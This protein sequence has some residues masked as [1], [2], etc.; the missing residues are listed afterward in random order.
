MR[1][2]KNRDKIAVLVV[3]VKSEPRYYDERKHMKLGTYWAQRT[4]SIFFQFCAIYRTKQQKYKKIIYSISL[5]HKI[6]VLQY[7][8]LNKIYKTTKVSVSLG[9][10][11]P[12]SYFFS[13]MSFLPKI[14]RGETNTTWRLI[15]KDYSSAHGVPETAYIFS[16]KLPF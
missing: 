12:L 7:I 13:K 16:S 1:F 11:G 5:M 14:G 3:K 6:Y 15:S 10:G 4:K 8:D 2:F 9:H